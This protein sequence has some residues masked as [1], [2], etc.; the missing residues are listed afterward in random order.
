MTEVEMN[1]AME[2]GIELA[3]DAAAEGCDLLGFGEMGIGN[4]TSASAIAAAL[5]GQPVEAVVG[6]GTGADD[7]CLARKRSAIERGL[8]LHADRLCWSWWRDQG[9]ARG[10][11]DPPQNGSPA[12][13]R[14]CDA[15]AVSRSRPCAGSAWEPRRAAFLY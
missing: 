12:P 6:R 15:S 3:R 7:A 4:T 14:F 5:T 8:A 11:G 9:V 2:T 10:S 13:Q 1:A